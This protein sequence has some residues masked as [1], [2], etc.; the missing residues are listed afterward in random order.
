MPA[1]FARQIAGL[2]RGI[3]LVRGHE[4]VEA[5]DMHLIGRVG[6]DCLPASRAASPD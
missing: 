5:D 4:T 3:A 1:R 6:A 2:A